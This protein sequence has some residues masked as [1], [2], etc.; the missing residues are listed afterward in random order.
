MEAGER[1]SNNVFAQLVPPHKQ[2]MMAEFTFG[3]KV[4]EISNVW[5]QLLMLLHVPRVKQRQRQRQRLPQR[6]RTEQGIKKGNANL[7][8]N[9]TALLTLRYATLTPWCDGI[10]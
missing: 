1:N 6:R 4:P 8:N 10:C 7:I 3:H 9:S 2:V 5:P